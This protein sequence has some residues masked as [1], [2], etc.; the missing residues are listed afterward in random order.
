MRVAYELVDYESGA[1]ENRPEL[2]K[3]LDLARKRKVDVVLVWKFDRFARSTKQLVTAL[4]EFRELGVDF[5]SYTENVDT[6]TPAGNALFTMV[7]AP[8]DFG[9][10]RCSPRRFFVSER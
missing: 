2:D 7:S 6:S 4:D 5:I 3:L 10:A 1:K 8:R 9:P